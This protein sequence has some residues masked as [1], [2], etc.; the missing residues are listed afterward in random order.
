MNDNPTQNNKRIIQMW[1]DIACST[2]LDDVDAFIDEFID[3][4]CEWVMMATRETFSRIDEIRQMW[5]WGECS[6][7]GRTRARRVGSRFCP[8]CHPESTGESRTASSEGNISRAKR[9]GAA[10]ASK[11]VRYRDRLRDVPLIEL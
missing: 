7:F 3:K 2:D 10:H 8:Y 1:S 11:N 6:V 9:I 4:D 5:H